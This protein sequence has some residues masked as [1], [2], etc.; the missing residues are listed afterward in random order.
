MHGLIVGCGYLGGRVARLW[1]E[2]GH[3]VSA[4]TRSPQTAERFEA[5][6]IRAVVGDVTQP[7]TLAALPAADVLLFAVGHDR[8]A[9]PSLREVYVEGLRHALGAL[10]GRV[11]RI[12]YVSSTS[13]Y[14]QIDGSWVD[15][16]SPT[17]PTT[18]SGRICLESER[19]L[20]EWTADTGVS[21]LILRLAGIYGPG[22]LLARI[23]GLM[24]GEPIGGLP[25][26]WLN[27]IHVEDAA[28]VAAACGETPQAGVLLVSDDRPVR[29][30]EFY[31]HLASLLNA[32]PPTFDGSRSAR[33]P[34]FNKRCRTARLRREG[35]V[36][37]HYPDYT[38]GL[39]AAIEPSGPAA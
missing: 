31:S 21:S 15:E 12:L 34:G 5:G 38:R 16:D 19:A 13:V 6:G 20:N 7:R 33:T 28:R 18:E 32:P 23:D 39:P 11:G 4:L 8:S 36:E 35:L 2:A 1:L 27:L 3:R 24:R 14:G 25:D 26:A 30:G 10:S 37:L 9:S 17:D 22:R 29:R